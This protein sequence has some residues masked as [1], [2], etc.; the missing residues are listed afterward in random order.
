MTNRFLLNLLR[1][2]C[3]NR[4]CVMPGCLIFPLTMHKGRS[5]FVLSSLAGPTQRRTARRSA[6]AP[7]R[8]CGANEAMRGG[9]A[10]SGLSPPEGARF[11]SHVG[12]RQRASHHLGTRGGRDGLREGGLAVADLRCHRGCRS[13]CVAWKLKIPPPPPPPK[14]YTYRYLEEVASF[15]FGLWLKVRDEF[16]F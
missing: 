4:D 5:P 10:T 11:G 7:T 14:F 2:E 1:S 9:A 13:G 15:H 16:T 6:T 3:V 8:G 12:R